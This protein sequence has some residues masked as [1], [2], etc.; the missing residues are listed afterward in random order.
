M[1][2][3]RSWDR[4]RRPVQDRPSRRL[5]RDRAWAFRRGRTSGKTIARRPP[6]IDP[7]RPRGGPGPAGCTETGILRERQRPGSTSVRPARTQ[8]SRGWRC[9]GP[10]WPS[11]GG[12]L[13]VGAIALL[14][15]V[16]SG[17][18]AGPSGASA[19]PSVAIVATPDAD[20]R[21]DTRPH[22]DADRRAHA[23]PG[24]HPHP[25]ADT[26]AHADPGTHPD[27]GRGTTDR[28]ARRR[29]R[30]RHAARSPS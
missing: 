7:S 13:R 17:S 4:R 21:T 19:P 12:S 15:L 27:A 29:P 25:G 22:A 11:S 24:P 5:A 9:N 10:W 26:H 8:A 18:L 30:S 6:A 20:T 2:R 16:A 1:R 23:D 28:R 14:L 3:L